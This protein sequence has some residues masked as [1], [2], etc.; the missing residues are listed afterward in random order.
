MKQIIL[1]FLIKNLLKGISEDDLLKIK[2]Q[3]GRIVRNGKLPVIIVEG[4]ELNPDRTNEVLRR[5]KELDKDEL[6]QLLY[7]DIQYNAHRLLYKSHKENDTMFAKAMI[8]IRYLLEKRI[9]T[10]SKIE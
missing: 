7:R 10:L 5:A 2:K 3:G 6:L 8:Y 4:K 1:N 9:K